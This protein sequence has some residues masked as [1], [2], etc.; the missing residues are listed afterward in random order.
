MHTRFLDWYVFAFV[1]IIVVLTALVM[2]P[3]EQWRSK[4][5]G[6]LLLLLVMA[7]DRFFLWVPSFSFTATLSMTRDQALRDEVS[8]ADA[9]APL[10][11]LEALDSV[12]L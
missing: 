11:R 7:F 8:I 5:L 10:Y 6:M 12:R 9:A 2:P 3:R 4:L 1:L